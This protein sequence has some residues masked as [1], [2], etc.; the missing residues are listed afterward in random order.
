MFATAGLDA[1]IFEGTPDGADEL[2]IISGYVGANPVQRA[3]LLP[4]RVEIVVGMVNDSGVIRSDHDFFRS[5]SAANARLKVRYSTSNE[6]HSKIYLWSKKGQAVKALVGS[7]NFTWSGLNSAERECLCRSPE[8]DLPD[9]SAYCRRVLN[10]SVDCWDP[11]A[12]SCIR[13]DLDV[14]RKSDA[15]VP[16][17]NERFE[18][19]LL[20]P[21]ND[22]VPTSSGLN[23]GLADGNV[24]LGDA[25]IPLR[26]GLIKQSKSLIPRKPDGRNTPVE[27]VWDDGFIMVGFFEGSQPIDGVKFPKQFASKPE[28]S[29]L[30]KYLRKRLGVDLKHLITAKDL[31]R[32]G[33]SS[34]SISKIG[35]AR[36]FMDFS[37]P[38]G[39]KGV[40][41]SQLELVKGDE[42]LT[43]SP[44]LIHRRSQI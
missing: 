30:G 17:A 6:V 21:R 37:P 28:K 26:V 1:L 44:G 20:D 18:I 23:W 33:R 41:T 8:V 31:Q 24:S 38:K 39:T 15:P 27:I 29:I 7:A 19:S 43:A 25:Y 35:E 12:E 22:E 2:T 9:L 34:V 36:Y 10:E 16:T 5:A 11:A 13:D 4:L 32:Y 3:S 40:L 42:L 14:P